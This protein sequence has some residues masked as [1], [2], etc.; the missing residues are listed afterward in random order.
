MVIAKL[1]SRVYVPYDVLAVEFAD[2]DFFGNEQIVKLFESATHLVKFRDLKKYEIMI[3]FLEKKKEENQKNIN[4]LKIELKEVKRNI[5]SAYLSSE[6]RNRIKSIMQKI[7]ENETNNIELCKKI[8]T[9]SDKRFIKASILEDNFTQMLV[10]F[11]FKCK[12][13]MARD[14]ALI[15][16]SM[17]E[18]DSDEKA[19]TEKI[20]IFIKNIKE[21]EKD[22]LVKL[23]KKLAN[24]ST[25]NFQVKEL[26]YSF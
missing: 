2:V 22:N 12:S 3:D 15:T 26:E 7:E 4:D 9:F 21:K 16:V 20:K 19:L 13:T 5:I 23:E 10:N 6:K 18:Y 25:D 11:G 24:L 8:E 14:D 1:K 17:F